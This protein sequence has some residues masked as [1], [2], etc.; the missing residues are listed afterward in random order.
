MTATGDM[1]FTGT[2]G[3]VSADILLTVDA[4]VAVRGSMD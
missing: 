2:S 1:S 3:G 4:I